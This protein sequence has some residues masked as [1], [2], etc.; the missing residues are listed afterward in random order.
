[1][2]VIKIAPSLLSADFAN[3]QKE[4][5]SLEKAGADM[6]HIDV[7]DGHFV[8]NLTFGPPIIKALRP[9]TTIPFDVHLMIITQNIRLK[10]ML[11]AERILSLSI[12]KQLSILTEL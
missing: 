8:P 7:M 10:I 5:S 3:L 11:T 6:I 1:V 9:H 12:L 4:I 2:K